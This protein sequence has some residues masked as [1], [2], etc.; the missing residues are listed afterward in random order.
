MTLPDGRM[1]AFLDEAAATSIL[2]R[3]QGE[4]LA[5]RC[6]GWWGAPTG[7]AQIGERAVFAE[8]GFALDTRER[9]VEVTEVEGGFVVEVAVGNDVYEVT[10]VPGRSVPTIACEAPGGLPLKPGQEWAITAGPTVRSAT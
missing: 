4:T 5:D 9:T 7:P 1:W 3:E 6:R 2:R 10:V 8:L